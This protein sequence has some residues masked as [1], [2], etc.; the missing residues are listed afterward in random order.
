MDQA[1]LSQDKV[2]ES[3]VSKLKESIKDDSVNRSTLVDSLCDKVAAD[4]GV[5][6][7]WVRHVIQTPKEVA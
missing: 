5:P 7:E 2:R 1:I 4:L 6:A 3:Y